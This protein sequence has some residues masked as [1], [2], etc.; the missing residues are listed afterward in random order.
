MSIFTAINDW[1]TARR[2]NRLESDLMRLQNKITFEP[3]YIPMSLKAQTAEEFTRRISEYLIWFMG[4]SKQIRDFYTQD[5]DSASLNYFWKTALKEYLKLHC[6][7]PSLISSKMAT[8]LFGGG[9]TANVEIYRINPEGNVSDKIDKDK[10]QAVEDTIQVLSEKTAL[11]DLLEEAAQ[12]E[13]WSGHLFVKFSY[14]TAL[15]QFPIIEV[16]DIRNAEVEKERG[17]TKSITF[18]NWYE[19]GTMTNK[20]VYC[21]KEI[22]TTNDAGEA[23]IQNKLEELKSNGDIVECALTDIEETK[24][25]DPEITF[26]GLKG[27]IAFD[28]PNKTPNNEFPD[29][30]YGASD[31]MGAIDSFDALDEVYSE[32]IKEI[33]DNKT[34]RY[35]PDNMMEVDDDG[36][37][38]FNPY[39][40]NHVKVHANLDQNS[41]N[42]INITEIA[43]KTEQHKEKWKVALTTAI[44][45]A[46][47]S[48]LALGITGLEAVN[49]GEQSQRERNKATLET[50]SMKLK[51]WTPFLAKLLLKLLE[52]NSWMQ[53]TLRVNQ[54]G[55][56]KIEV[57][58]TNCNVFVKF[59]DY[60]TDS[61]K[62]KRTELG[63]AKQQGIMSIEQ[64][65]EEQYPDW[66]EEQ[67]LAE[68]NRIKFE[69]NMSFDTPDTLQG[70]TGKTD[71]QNQ[72]PDKEKPE[73]KDNQG[74][75]KEQGINNGPANK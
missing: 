28:K 74:K 27:M 41:K 55:V 59:G 44:N 67:K 62:D 49:A 24:E 25:L 66:S 36:V 18:K 12:T 35:I 72:N 23:V 37:A 45:K 69:Q 63:N 54:E 58:W 61:I 68:I 17:I 31:Y 16:V 40:T 5:S 50:R 15:S 75:E 2:L 56:D 73:E 38:K 48:P 9:Y 64:I 53:R 14:D 60:I 26:T 10:S 57:D 43:D 4:N 39:V 52:F 65:I 3:K 70:L 11:K 46:G 71:E 6:G 47:L 42:E 13:S 19:Y 8:I 33:R 32:I 21:H 20:R 1:F 30:P 29:S 51:K 7:V 22:Y 34:M